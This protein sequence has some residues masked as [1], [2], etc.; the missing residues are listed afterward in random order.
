MANS[1]QKFELGMKAIGMAVI[2]ED[3]LINMLTELIS[4]AI[5]SGNKKSNSLSD[6][7][8][9]VFSQQFIKDERLTDILEIIMS[10]V[11]ISGFL[12]GVNLCCVND[13]RKARRI[14]SKY[15]HGSHDQIDKM[16][17]DKEQLE[18]IGL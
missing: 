18:Q 8:C 13:R 9:V 15:F 3:K 6:Q 16:I 10:H 1:R 11:V 2:Q 17:G 12:T 5:K 7:D 14:F 4:I